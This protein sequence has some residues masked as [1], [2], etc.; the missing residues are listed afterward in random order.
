MIGTTLG[1]YRIVE[2]I[3]A[4]GMGVVYRAHDER[5]DRDVAIK[6][7]PE[8]V[9]GDP[10]RL[11]R[12]EREAKAVAALSH[13][14]ILE[15]FDFDTEDDVTFA[16]T[17]LLEGQSLRQ[18]ITRLVS[19]WRSAVTI[20]AAIADGLAAAHKREII[21]RDLKPE[22]VFLTIDDQVKILDFGLAKVLHP[23]A[24]D[25][26]GSE[27]PT[28]SI[29]TRAGSVM[30]TAGYMSPEQVRGE[31]VDHRTDIFALGCLL[32]E[33]LCGQR[34][35]PGNSAAEVTAAILSR[36]PTP[37]RQI[38]CE[39]PVDVQP[40]VDRCLMK[41]PAKRFQNASD[42]SFALRSLITSS[43]SGDPTPAA[44]RRR[45]WRWVGA[46]AGIVIATVVGAVILLGDRTA[47][48]P[49][50]TSTDLNPNLVA[51]A[52]FENRTGKPE[53]DNLGLVAADWL[54]NVLARIDAIDVVPIGLGVESR[55]GST[56]PQE[57]ADT[58]GADIVVTGAYYLEGDSLRFQANLTD[59]TRGSL[60]RSLEPSGGPVD[61]P[62]AAIEPMASEVAGA[63]ASL[64][65]SWD[66]DFD[67][68]LRPPGF[69]AYRE[70]I[71]GM[72]FFFVDN[73]RAL[74]HYRRAT[75]LDPDFVAPQLMT[76]SILRASARFSEARA[77]VDRLSDQRQRLN[78]FERFSLEYHIAKLDGDNQRAVL[79]MRRCEELAPR[80]AL[81]KFGL[82]YNLRACA[83]PR[84]ALE[85]ISAISDPGQWTGTG[86]CSLP[87][88]VLTDTQHVLGFH[89]GEL[90]SARQGVEACG[91][92]VYF[93][94]CR[95]RALIGKG[96]INLAEE[97]LDDGL[98]APD[99]RRM[100]LL[101]FLDIAR[102][103]DAHGHPALAL[104][105][106]ERG[107]AHAQDHLSMDE[108]SEWQR[109][110]Y[111]QLLTML[112]RLDEALEIMLA[113]N[114]EIP[115]DDDV[116]GWLGIVAAEH[117]DNEAAE[118]FSTMLRDLD[119]PHLLGWDSFY[120]A[121]IAAHLGRSDEAMGLLREAFSRGYEWNIGLHASLELK[122]LR[123]HPEVEAILCPDG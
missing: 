73:Q 74:E 47:E 21:H 96:E 87:F 115:D 98:K 39:V 61:Q 49:A 32:H 46:A 33:L 24:P 72:E 64:F 25:G 43:G 7:L 44:V 92:Q 111:V 99:A 97:A 38:G 57:V 23:E 118:R 66:T 56:S 63:V 8:E 36:Q 58:T 13:P 69:E 101:L 82:A 16:V 48:A 80:S 10:D 75:E 76:L 5:L 113:L 77:I 119:H 104:S 109:L 53:L 112:G 55:A 29:G 12:F 100:S 26:L 93:Q 4:G 40:I 90:E 9:A 62:M 11:H 116:L 42:L 85:V 106:A 17:E 103:L 54:T 91:N 123:N 59:A 34:A 15:I 107:V 94:R 95:A 22:N 79:Q 52:A 1:H 60:L 19:G 41:S 83:R 51:A 30:G 65:A 84:E 122:P 35:F 37:L 20:C 88:T 71:A 89:D 117:R 78:P 67:Q 114:E 45:A 102:E 18:H 86:A 68:N 70:Y 28:G 6:V 81:I 105:V 2:Q 3:G 31:P 110:W 50:E 108:A 120:R 121:G 27:C 14:N